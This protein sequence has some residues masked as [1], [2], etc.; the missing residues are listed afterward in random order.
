MSLAFHHFFV[1]VAHGAPVVDELVQ[2]GFVEGSKNSHPGQGT[3]NRRLFFENGM[4]EFIWVENFTEIQSSH[5][6]PTRLRE[7]GHFQQSGFAPF[8]IAL[9]PAPGSGQ[10]ND[11]PFKGWSYS[12]QY[13]PSGFSIW[14]AS[15][16]DYPW[17]PKIFYL[18]F[19]RPFEENTSGKEPILHPNGCARI[20]TIKISMS[21]PR[22]P[23][24]DAAQ[25]M[26]SIAKIKLIAS[27]EPM[28][29]ITISGTTNKVLELRKWCPLKIT[30]ESVLTN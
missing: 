3:A 23:L 25:K 14:E 22:G 6:A 5:T 9:C 17:E 7:R 28:A 13:L 4:L 12:P 10:A 18:P 19:A 27:D 1:F 2:L 16:E 26:E 8:G 15:N 30:L 29:E 21:K 11:M 20:E 24:S